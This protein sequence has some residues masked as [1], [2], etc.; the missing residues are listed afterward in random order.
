ML[1]H[2]AVHKMGIDNDAHMVGMGFGGW[3]AAELAA[4]HLHASTAWSWSAPPA[5]SPK[6]AKSPT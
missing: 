1:L 2:S 6:K 4:M 3:V 5:S